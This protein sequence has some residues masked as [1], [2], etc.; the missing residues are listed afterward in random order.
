M[1]TLFDEKITSAP[2]E[3]LLD[4]YDALVAKS[5]LCTQYFDDY[6]VG[7]ENWTQKLDPEDVLKHLAGYKAQKERVV[8]ELAQLRAEIAAKLT[9]IK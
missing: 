1:A 2:D 3:T 8:S 4:R 6:F 9:A 5:A 7:V